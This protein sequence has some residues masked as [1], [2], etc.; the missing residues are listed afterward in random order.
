MGPFPQTPDSCIQ[1]ISSHYK[2]APVPRT[3]SFSTI[4]LMLYFL[5]YDLWPR[6]WRRYCVVLSREP[7]ASDRE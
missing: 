5:S 1:G 2:S 3:V 7:A 6:N 4:V